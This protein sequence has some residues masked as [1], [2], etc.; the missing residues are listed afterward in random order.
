MLSLDDKYKAELRIKSFELAKDLEDGYYPLD[1]KL[2]NSKI[3]YEYLVK[4]DV[5]LLDETKD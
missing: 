1:L 5:T 2:T 4:D 3:I